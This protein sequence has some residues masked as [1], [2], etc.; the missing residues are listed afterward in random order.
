MNMIIFSAALIAMTA[1]NTFMEEKVKRGNIRL[2]YAPVSKTS[3]YLSKLLSTYIF[4]VI[5]YS[6][7]VWTAQTIFKLNFGGEDLPY[8]LLLLHVFCSLAAVSAPCFAAF[9]KMKNRRIV[10]CKFQLLFC[11]LWRR[12]FRNS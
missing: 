10:S 12:F 6:M 4:S 8:I 9:L 11:F 3:I 7:N 5:L 2:V 1:S